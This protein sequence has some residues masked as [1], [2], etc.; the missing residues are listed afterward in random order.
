[1]SRTI[2]PAE[3]AAFSAVHDVFRTRSGSP[4][5]APSSA[6]FEDWTPPE[7]WVRRAYTLSDL[8]LLTEVH[9]KLS[10]SP[11]AQ[12]MLRPRFSVSQY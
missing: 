9:A 6:F 2:Q 3:Y 11:E 12:V 4:A 5:T 10:G 8:D 7:E 1:M